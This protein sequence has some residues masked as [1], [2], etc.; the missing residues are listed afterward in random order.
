MV[1]VFQSVL[2]SLSSVFRFLQSIQEQ[3]SDLKP[4]F[5]VQL[6]REYATLPHTINKVR[7][8]HMCIL[9]KNQKY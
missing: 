6:I 8:V 7:A 9:L 4:K 2:M 1:S 3:E 5:S